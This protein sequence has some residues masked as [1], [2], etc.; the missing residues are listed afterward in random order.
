MCVICFGWRLARMSKSN[1]TNNNYSATNDDDDDDENESSFRLSQL[2]R[3]P[4][5]RVHVPFSTNIRTHE[6][7][8]SIFFRDVS[9][10]HV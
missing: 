6:G 8:K 10:V 7:K 9:L 1:T 5:E 2:C 3:N 4:F